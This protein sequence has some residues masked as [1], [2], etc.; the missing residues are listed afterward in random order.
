M[1]DFADGP[2]ALFDQLP[3]ALGEVRKRRADFAIGQVLASAKQVP[4]PSMDR[5]RAARFLKPPTN[6]IT[7]GV[8]LITGLVHN[9]MPVKEEPQPPAAERGRSGCPLVPDGPPG[10]RDRWHLGRARGG[11]PQA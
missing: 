7:I 10:R 11:L 2:D 9:L 3:T 6:P 4:L 1:H 5:V 8:T